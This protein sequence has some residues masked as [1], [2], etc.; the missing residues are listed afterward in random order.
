[1]ASDLRALVDS[2]GVGACDARALS[3]LEAV[4][5]GR[6]RAPAGAGSSAPV[7]RCEL[8]EPNFPT[9]ATR[10]SALVQPRR[11][12]SWPPLRGSRHT[13]GTSPSAWRRC[14]LPSA[15][16]AS[17]S[18]PSRRSVATNTGRRRAHRMRRSP[19]PVFL[20]LAAV[21]R[22]AR[23]G[24]QQRRAGLAARQRRAG[25]GVARR[26][27]RGPR[28]LLRCGCGVPP[29]DRLRNCSASGR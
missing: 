11:T 12:A 24:A 28:A 20:R 8:L 18:R 1:M 6:R 23:T 27:R 4:A 13:S 9:P 14:V 16:T 17:R 22:G 10:T 3:A 7:R 26:R 25:A 5:Q 19:R 2:L 29:W 21:A 15:C